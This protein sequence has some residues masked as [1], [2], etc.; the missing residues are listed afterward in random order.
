MLSVLITK[1]RR[2]KTFEDDGYIYDTDCDV[3]FMDC[4]YL[5]THQ[6]V[7]IKNVQVFVC[8]QYLN[9]VIFKQNQRT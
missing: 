6:V 2:E 1:K 3:G 9:K 4:T 5:Q 7:Y 8:Q